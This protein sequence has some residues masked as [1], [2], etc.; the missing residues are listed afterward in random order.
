MKKYLFL[1]A[2]ILTLGVGFTS[3][4]SQHQWFSQFQ[5]KDGKITFRCQSSCVLLLGDLADNDQLVVEWGTRQGDG[6]WGYGY[7]VGENIYSASLLPAGAYKWTFADDQVHAQL[8]DEKKQIV[9]LVGGPL[10]VEDVHIALGSRSSSEVVWRAWK[11]FRTTEQLAPYSINLHYGPMI[12]SRSWPVFGLVIMLIVVLVVYVTRKKFSL[13]QVLYSSIV[14]LIVITVVWGVRL[15]VDDIVITNHN[16]ST[17]SVDHHNVF[18]LG[19]YIA[20]TEKVRAHLDLDNVSARRGKTCTMY[21]KSHRSWPVDAHRNSVYLRPCTPVLTGS[22]AD[23][24]LYYNI[25]SEAGTGAATLLTWNNFT[26]FQTR[27]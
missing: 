13:K 3:A 9:F 10:K 12:G 8:P 16:T 24:Q 14:T 22:M 5:E 11:K 7:L 21:A 15:L 2:A 20:V 27:P 17:F 26:L 1:A 19:D 25:P 23:Y 18:D 6:T 4:A